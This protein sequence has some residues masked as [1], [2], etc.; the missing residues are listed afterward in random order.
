MAVRRGQVEALIRIIGEDKISALLADVTDSLNDTKDKTDENKKATD[1]YRVSIEGAKKGWGSI[2]TGINQAVELAKKAIDAVKAIG[3]QAKIGGQEIGIERR[4]MQL[5]EKIGGAGNALQELK[6]ASAEGLGKTDIE[7]LANDALTAGLSLGQVSKLFEVSAKI[8]S[9]RGLEQIDVTREVIKGI[10]EQSDSVFRAS[11]MQVDFGQ[12]VAKA[13]AQLGLVPD[14]MTVNERRTVSFNRVLS[15]MNNTFQ[16]L[17]VDETIK[18]LNQWES[19]LKD[20]ITAKRLQALEEFGLAPQLKKVHRLWGDIVDVSTS[21]VRVTD[22]HTSASQRRALQAGKNAEADKKRAKIAKQLNAILAND[23]TAKQAIDLN[24]TRLAGKLAAEQDRELQEVKAELIEKYHLQSSMLMKAK[25]D[26][27]A[28]AKAMDLEAAAHKDNANAI[29][30]SLGQVEKAQQRRRLAAT[31]TIRKIIEQQ[32]LRR[33]QAIEEARAA[34]SIGRTAM[35]SKRYKEVLDLLPPALSRSADEAR[36]AAEATE[37]LA[38]AG[39]DYTEVVKAKIAE[40]DKAAD[41]SARM[42]LAEAAVLNQMGRGKAAAARFVAGLKLINKAAPMTTGTLDA[43]ARAAAQVNAKLAESLKGQIE[44]YRWGAKQG[45]AS[46]AEVK[47]LEALQGRLI[48]LAKKS[49]RIPGTGGGKDRDEELLAARAKKRMKEKHWLSLGPGVGLIPKKGSPY[50][51]FWLKEVAANEAM[52]T[53]EAEASRQKWDKRFGPEAT[54]TRLELIREAEKLD[55]NIKRGL[56]SE[57]IKILIEEAKATKA[58]VDELNQATLAKAT[59]SFQQATAFAGQ[60]G[61]QWVQATG[62]TI[63]QIAAEFDRLK[64]IQK[65]VEEGQISSAEAWGK[66]A[67]GMLAA[68]GNIAAGF[69]EDT[70]TRAAVQSAFEFASAIAAYAFGDIRGGVMHTLAGTMFAAVAAGATKGSGGAGGGASKAPSTIT[71]PPTQQQTAPANQVT[72]NISGTIVGNDEEAGRQLA[73]MI[74]KE[75]RWG[76]MA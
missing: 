16:G 68:S 17:E 71:R 32:T 49:V 13:A 3:E 33:S 42:A 58:V 29:G 25:E 76:A 64:P 75:M 20:L 55:I 27:E 47:K 22:K 51:K 19:A 54:K 65:A 30:I 53:K 45:L 69:I 44:Y 31:E 2:A 72:L 21:I 73:N 34:D 5:T 35:A 4:F 57:R 23:P 41:S 9:A 6:R 10:V 60:Y 59:A 7:R 8:A 38:S 50:Y 66:A 36:I 12:S 46:E 1:R 18:K 39:S 48:G 56:S 43:V 40:A 26:S 15:E 63:T 67:P 37:Y 14:L 52:A 24:L 61:N 11:G 74:K 62:N 28:F 70:E